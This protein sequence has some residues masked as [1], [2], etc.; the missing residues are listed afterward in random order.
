[1]YT[2]PMHR[3]VGLR[4]PGRCPRCGMNLVAAGDRSAAG[5]LRSIL[6]CC[7]DWRVLTALATIALGVLVLQPKL[8]FAALPVLLVAICPL[9]CLLMAW[10]MRGRQG[11]SAGDGPTPAGGPEAKLAQLE[12]EVADLTL[13]LRE[14]DGDGSAADRG[15]SG[16][17]GRP[18]PVRPEPI[19]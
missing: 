7:L 5:S 16:A 12:L 3:D 19:S 13:Q 8:F 17:G 1:M 2:C 11:Q 4:E 14:L 9:S 6:A 15:G 10:H 18:R